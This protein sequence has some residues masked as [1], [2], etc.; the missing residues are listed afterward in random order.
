MI[1][2]KNVATELIALLYQADGAV[3]EA[4]RIAQEKCPPDEFVAFRRGMADVIY[5]LF[6]KG[7][8][9]ICRRHPELIPE[10]ETLDGGQGK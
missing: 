10:G 8:V 2:N 9:P 7:V 4:I 6:E 3:N 5:T 1:E